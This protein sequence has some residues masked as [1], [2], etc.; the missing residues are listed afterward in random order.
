M[1]TLIATV[2]SIYSLFGFGLNGANQLGNMLGCLLRVLSQLADFLGHNG[3]ATAML[4]SSSCLN[5]SVESQKVGLPRNINDGF[6]NLT[7]FL[8]AM[9]QSIY[10]VG[11][12]ANHSFHSIHMLA[13]NIDAFN[14]LIYSG[15]YLVG[16]VG[17]LLGQFGYIVNTADNIVQCRRCFFYIIVLGYRQ[18]GNTVNGISYGGNN[19]SRFV[20]SCGHGFSR[21]CQLV[22]NILYLG[23]DISDFA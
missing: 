17:S 22:G 6:Y 16:T 8:G 5:S 2:H 4:A 15:T 12:G 20:N 10:L 18:L 1:N 7:D 3:K 13:N 11:R 14:T 23:G 9:A 21:I 19:L